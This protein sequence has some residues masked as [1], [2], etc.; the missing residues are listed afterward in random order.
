MIILIKYKIVFSISIVFLLLLSTFSIYANEVDWG[1]RYDEIQAQVCSRISEQ[2]IVKYSAYTDDKNGLPLNN[3]KDV[4]VPGKVVILAKH[5][6]SWGKGKNFKSEVL[7]NPSWLDLT[8]QANK[9]ILTTGDQHHRYL[10][11]FAILHIQDGIKYIVL[12]MG[13]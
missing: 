3:L 6:P 5:D 4:A 10:E 7:D 1:K 9:M 13:S 8:I 12:H 2:C 11:G